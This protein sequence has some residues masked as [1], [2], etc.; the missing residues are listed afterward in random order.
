MKRRNAK[1]K[2]TFPVHIVMFLFLLMRI[3]AQRFSLRL[4][5]NSNPFPFDLLQLLNIVESRN[6]SI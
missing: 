3:S 6:E 5:H 4:N 1:S 2:I